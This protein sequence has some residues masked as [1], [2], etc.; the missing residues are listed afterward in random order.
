MLAP[1]PGV[2]LPD[3]HDCL[4]KGSEFRVRPQGLPLAPEALAGAPR[5][6][7]RLFLVVFGLG[8][9]WRS[10]GRQ[11]A[12]PRA[13]QEVIA[14]GWDQ[15]ATGSAAL[16]RPSGRAKGC[17]VRALYI[18]WRGCWVLRHPA[19]LD[20]N[21]MSVRGVPRSRALPGLRSLPLPTPSRRL[22]SPLPPPAFAPHALP[23]RP[24]RCPQRRP[25]RGAGQGRPPGG[26]R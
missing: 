10:G 8:S 12:E 23:P 3:G 25:F 15:G 6:V 5:W 11:R 1:R 17:R 4:L 9:G 7:D 22:P 21:L 26:A 24:Q 16:N 14:D 20:A 18:T 2:P 19:A 13:G